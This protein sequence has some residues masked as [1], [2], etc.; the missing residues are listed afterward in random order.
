LP[1]LVDECLE[2]SGLRAHYLAEREGADRLENLAELVTATAQFQEE[3]D[4]DETPLVG[5]LTHASLEAGDHEAGA[6]EDALQLMTVHAAKG[7]EFRAVFLSGLEEGLFPHDNSMNDLD[8]IEEERR[9]MY[10]AVTRARERLYLSYAGSRMLHGQVRYGVVSRFVDEIPAEFCKWI[11][12]PDRQANYGHF[13]SGHQNS[14][15]DAPHAGRFEQ[16]RAPYVSNASNAADY[17]REGAPDTSRARFET[18]RPDEHPFAVGQNVMHAKF[19]E[20]VVVNFEGRGLDA[21]VQVKFRH[22]GV[23]WLA[24]QYAKLTAI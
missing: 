12:L 4:G 19:G 22:E 17:G 14:F 15:F 9:L 1:E 7:L 20:G 23:K 3:Y 5:F 6:H 11:V 18:R 13:A 21:R 10:V 2:K 8:G 16:A 24:L